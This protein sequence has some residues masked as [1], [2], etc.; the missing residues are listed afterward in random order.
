MSQNQVNMTARNVWGKYRY[1]VLLE[2]DAAKVPLG[3]S[4]LKATTLDSIV[5]KHCSA[6]F[7]W[8][9]L[10]NTGTPTEVAVSPFP[11]DIFVDFCK[12]VKIS[13]LVGNITA[14]SFLSRAFHR[15]FNTFQK[16]FGNHRHI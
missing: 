15:I 5:V 7:W 8:R 1:V 13:I 11:K 14:R 10:V 4:R 9:L 16:Y 12:K 3:G 6:P 2:I